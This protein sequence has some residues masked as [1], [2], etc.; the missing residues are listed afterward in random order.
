MLKMRR[1]I[2]AIVTAVF[3]TANLTTGT[4]F[5]APRPEAPGQGRARP[6]IGILTNRATAQQFEIQIQTNVISLG[7]A[8]GIDSA[9]FATIYTASIP[10]KYLLPPVSIT[11]WSNSRQVSEVDGTVSVR[12]TLT[13]YYSTKYNWQGA[14]VQVDHYDAR[15]DRLDPAVSWSNNYVVV[16]CFGDFLE[17]GLCN[18]ART[19]VVNPTNSGTT[20]IIG[21]P[22]AGKHVFISDMTHQSAIQ[23]TTLHRGGSTWEF[24]VTVGQGGGF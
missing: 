15:W 4:I 20:Y 11:S 18:D 23:H 5:A 1:A 2:L 21:V 17:G 14:W 13:Q 19:A 8:T 12:L 22:W 3:A 24:Q 16:G 9:R 10:T 7:D 6:L